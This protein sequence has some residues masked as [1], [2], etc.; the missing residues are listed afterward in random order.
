MEFN[1]DSINLDEL[2]SS[3]SPVIN[4]EDLTPAPVNTPDKVVTKADDI[5]IVPAVVDTDGI[6]LEELEGSDLP[7]LDNKDKTAAE[8]KAEKDNKDKGAPVKDNASLSSQDTFTSLASA[9]VE[10]G[11]FSSLS[12]EEISEIKDVPTLLASIDKQTKQN[13]LADLN[14]DQR[15]YLEALRAGVPLENYAARKTAATQYNNIEDSAIQKSPEVA[16][17]LIR[18]SFLIKGFDEGTAEHY[19]SLSAK[20]DN[21]YTDAFSAKNALVAHE[22][23]ELQKELDKA[24]LD[25][26]NN[27]ESET[28]KIAALKSKLDG[29]SEILKGIKVTTAN[30]AKIFSSMTTPTQMDNDTPL[31]EVMASYKDDEEYKVRLHTLH[32]VTKGFTDF[33]KLMQGSKKAAVSN[34]EAVLNSQGSGVSG[35][36]LTHAAGVGQTTRDIAK[37]L[38]NLNF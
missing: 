9:L 30:K 10:T 7:I 29:E 11:A 8:L 27:L 3:E 32:V 35:G 34:L 33:S 13:E 21:F 18:R 36:N 26:A 20:S 17:E 23:T 4:K 16:K 12:E 22:N 14:E 2:A 38:E 6:D 1:F 24:K 31:N 19:A 28:A 37:A 15:T 25:K 5:E